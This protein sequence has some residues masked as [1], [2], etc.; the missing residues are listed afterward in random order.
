MEKAP[1]RQAA[2]DPPE[3]LGDGCC[4]TCSH[5]LPAKHQDGKSKIQFAH[6]AKTKRTSDMHERYKHVL[7]TPPPPETEYDMCSTVRREVGVRCPNYVFK[8]PKRMARFFRH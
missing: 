8:E 6:C 7:S 5:I 2:P 3:P 1:Y 4:E